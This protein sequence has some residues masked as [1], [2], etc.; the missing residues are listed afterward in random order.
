MLHWGRAGGADRDVERRIRQIK[1]IVRIGTALRADI[2]LE[3]TLAQIVEAASATLGFRVAVLNLVHPGADHLEVVAAVGLDEAERRRLMEAPPP[4]ERILAVMRPEFCISHSYFIGHEYKHL[5]EGVPV[6]TLYT[7]AP[8]GAPRGPDSWH[9]EDVLLV[10]LASSRDGGLLGILSFDQPDDGKR[11]SLETVEILELFASQ[12]ATAVETSRLFHEREAERRELDAQLWKLLGLLEQVRQNQLDVRAQLDGQ[13]LAPIGQALNSVL[14]ALGG[15]LWEARSASEVVNTNATEMREAAVQLAGSAQAQA[16]QIAEV[17][18][19]IEATARNV[20]KIAGVAGETSEAA[21]EAIEVSQIG[22]EA[23]ERAAEGMSA[24]REMALQSLKKMKRLSESSQE[25]GDI[26]QLVSD[27]ATK[28]NLLALNAAIEAARA[29]DHGRGFSIVAKEIR[30][31]AASTAEATKQINAR[32]HAI[33]HET[34]GVVVTIEHSAEQVVAQSDAAQQAGAA[35]HHVDLVVRAIAEAVQRM[36]ATAT[37]QADAAALVS[38][39][40]SGIAQATSH[41]RDRMEQMRASMD[42]LVELSQSLL[43]S[44]SVFRLGARPGVSV[45]PRAAGGLASVEDATEPMPAM[46]GE[47][48]TQSGSLSRLAPPSLEANRAFALP[49]RAGRSGALEPIYA[50]GPLAPQPG[51]GGRSGDSRPAEGPT[52]RP[53]AP[54]DQ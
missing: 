6:V 2:G 11:P 19:S 5:L 22:R 28:T 20:R 27:I 12:A 10:P 44:I 40:A 25:I 51:F 52:S 23:A 42:R 1:E 53:A 30:G 13:T 4:A 38:Y 9:P 15:V 45:A 18:R 54:D 17:S 33:Q 50:T 16:D 7:S 21:R 43:G 35:L 31:L 32:I 48:G 41:T 37:Q 14:E 8:P 24:A 49:E 26:V 3:Q 29:G 47:S 36:S 34:N 46:R 39:S